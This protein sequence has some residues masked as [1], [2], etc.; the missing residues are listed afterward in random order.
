[1]NL[2]PAQLRCCVWHCARLVHAMDGIGVG[3]GCGLPAK[4]QPAAASP[5]DSDSCR[6]ARAAWHHY[7]AG[8]P[9]ALRNAALTPMVG[10]VSGQCAAGR[11]GQQTAIGAA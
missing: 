5:R 1:M 11:D 10:S 2:L 7:G 6:P 3:V 8:P 9:L 4:A